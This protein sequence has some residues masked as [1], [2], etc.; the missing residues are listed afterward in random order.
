M[1]IF[2]VNLCRISLNLYRITFRRIHVP[3]H[4]PASIYN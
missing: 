4:R 3:L 2:Y 1:D